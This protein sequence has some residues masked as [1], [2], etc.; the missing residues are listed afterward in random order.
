M[1]GGEDFGIIPKHFGVPGL[2][3]RVGGAPKGH[4]ASIG[5]HSSKWAVD[6]EP[7]LKAGTAAFARGLLDLLGKPAGR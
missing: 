7:T 2:Q 4:D 6:P 1:M 3:F 5:L